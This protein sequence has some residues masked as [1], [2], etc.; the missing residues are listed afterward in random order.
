MQTPAD[1]VAATHHLANRVPRLLL[2]PRLIEKIHFSRNITFVGH[3]PWPAE[4][5][6]NHHSLID[7][8][9]LPF[10][11]YTILYKTFAL[12]TATIILIGRIPLLAIRSTIVAVRTSISQDPFF[13]TIQ[14]G[15]LCLTKGNLLLILTADELRDH[16][17]S[18][19]H[20]PHTAI[21]RLPLTRA[22]TFNH[23]QNINIFILAPIH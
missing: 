13:D 19:F 21:P 4:T 2:Q 22:E 5:I 6:S 15:G 16:L 1:L 20:Q 18:T 14:F 17:L 3:R 9:L 8:R 7:D 11:P 12:S 23:R 10:R